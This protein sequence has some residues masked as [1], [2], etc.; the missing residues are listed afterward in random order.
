LAANPRLRWVA[1]LWFVAAGLSL[2]A[3]VLR[4][5]N[6]EPVRWPLLAA[7]VFMAALGWTALRQS[8]SSGK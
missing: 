5:V 6:D 4:L 2:T 8:R 7:T 3:A 1:V